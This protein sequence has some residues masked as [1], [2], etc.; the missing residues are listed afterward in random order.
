MAKRR[1]AICN[2]RRQDRSPPDERQALIDTTPRVGLLLRRPRPGRDVSRQKGPRCRDGCRAARGCLRRVWS[3]CLYRRRSVAGSHR[4][5]DFRSLKDSS[6]PSSHA[7]PFSTRD[8]E[9]SVPQREDII[10]QCSKG[11]A[12]KVKAGR[13]NF[14]VMSSVT[15]H[16][17]HPD[18]V[19]H[20]IWEVLDPDAI[21]W[22]THHGYH[23]WSGHHALPRDVGHGTPTSQLTMPWSTGSTSIRDPCYAKT[24]LNRIRLEDMRLVGGEYFELQCWEPDY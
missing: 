3:R 15:E 19:M 10:G 5:R 13:P 21:F 18:S 1:N 11:V 9:W 4:V 17:E 22:V 6:V 14:A 16:L 8:I 23:S 24:D 20:A 12:P 7:F 2:R